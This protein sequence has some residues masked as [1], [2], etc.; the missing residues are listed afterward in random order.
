MSKIFNR[1]L[2]ILLSL[3]LLAGGCT[4]FAH[5]KSKLE[6]KTD[7]RSQE[8]NSGARIANQRTINELDKAKA[9]LNTATVPLTNGPV[10][11][12]KTNFTDADKSLTKASATAGV[13]EE[14]LRRN[15]NLLGKPAEDQ[16]KV[17]DA[18]TSE[19]TALKLQAQLTQ[20]FKEKQEES[21]KKKIDELER[22]LENYGAKYEQE[23]ND[24]IVSY[25]KWGGLALLLIVGP[26]ALAIFFPPFLSLIVSLVPAL[27][28][29]VGV[30]GKITNGMVRGIGDMRY[31]LQ[32]QAEFESGRTEQKM[33]TAEEVK[34]ML[35][36]H[37]N[38][39][40]KQDVHVVDYLR[41]I[42]NA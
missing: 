27:T 15:E 37:L 31:T 36:E 35:D 32:K 11:I 30:P 5:N 33:Y 40:L 29:F 21:W 17:I 22:K 4:Y 39:H 20:T 10:T 1:P 18:L 24:K 7:I 6:D 8:L 26:I 41:K 34:Q 38:T 13:A 12:V 23:R 42:N 19:N 16:T 3:S 2:I 28:S 9:L 14:M 25:F